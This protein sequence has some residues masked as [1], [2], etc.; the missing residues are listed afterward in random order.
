MRIKYKVARYKK[1]KIVKFLASLK[2]KN[3]AKEFT[4]IRRRRD[5]PADLALVSKSNVVV[6]QFLIGHFRVPKPLVFKTRL[7]GNRQ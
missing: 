4:A 6:L 2:G 7:S 3:M 5:R 1:I